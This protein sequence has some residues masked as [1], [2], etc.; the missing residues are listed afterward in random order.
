[1]THG[2]DQDPSGRDTSVLDPSVSANESARPL[3]PGGP[4]PDLASTGSAIESSRGRS[5]SMVVVAV[6][7]LLYTLYFAR[8]FL[9]PI[10]FAVL[11]SYLLSPVVRTLARLHIPPPLGALIIIL[12]LVAI[13][14]MGGYELSGPV[15]GWA[16]SAPQTL[17]TAEL[18]LSKLIRPIERVTRTAEQV[19]TAANVTAGKAGGK[20]TEV[21]MKGP[22]L[23]ARA[24][25]TTQRFAGSIL[26]VII[27][28]Y[29]LLA[30]GDLFLQKLIKVLPS[31]DKK[32]AVEI[33]RETESSVST[34]LLTATSVNVGEGIVIT[35]LMYLLGM[36]NPALWGALVAVLEFIPYLG[37]LVMVA[38][39][40]VA[41]LTTFNSVGHALLIPA[42]YLLVNLVQGNFVSPLLLGHRLALNQ[43][44][45]FVGLAFWFWIW[46]IAGA[47]IA[48]PLMAT[49]KIFCDHIDM[50]APVGEFLGR[51]DDHERRAIVR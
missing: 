46:G 8:E 27:L 14:G 21:V 35:G 6:L 26:E 51:R 37:A 4:S 40:S 33:A 24:F 30:A 1:M 32:K 36:P 13:V 10:T 15:E 2:N 42:S 29:F 12:A 43:V 16:V 9:L 31:R 49:F 11:L 39:L 22:S 41:A 45:L 19:V 3:A 17:A 18:K 38:I 48:V 44:A 47:F 25:G 23:I 5:I 50:L 20:P 34:Y 7:A 28:L